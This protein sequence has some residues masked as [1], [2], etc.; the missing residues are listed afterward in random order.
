MSQQASVCRNKVHA[1][2]KKEKE[3]CHDKKFLC[4]DIAEEVC[5]GD[6]CDTLNSLLT[7]IKANGSGTFSRKSLLRCNIKE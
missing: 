1:E 2:L 5:E 7:V 3:L 6:C 4:R